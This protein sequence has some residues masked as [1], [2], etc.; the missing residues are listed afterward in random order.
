MDCSIVSVNLYVGVA[1]HDFFIIT[2]RLQEL[3]SWSGN[4]TITNFYL[5]TGGVRWTGL[6]KMAWLAFKWI[7]EF[8]LVS[9]LFV[10]AIAI[11]TVLQYPLGSYLH[12]DFISANYCR[13]NEFFCIQVHIRAKLSKLLIIKKHRIENQ[14]LAKPVFPLGSFLT[15]IIICG[16]CFAY[17]HQQVESCEGQLHLIMGQWHPICET[18]T[19][20]KWNRA[21][22]NT[23]GLWI[24]SI[25]SLFQTFTPDE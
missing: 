5:S 7:P 13:K 25:A 6:E 21:S 18:K 24:F 12:R 23:S 1:Y 15:S 10:S 2:G 9:W 11:M 16:I 17:A 20:C 4:W 22:R 8:G 3:R 19:I 14:S